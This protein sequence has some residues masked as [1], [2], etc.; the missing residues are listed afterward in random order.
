VIDQYDRSQIGT[1]TFQPKDEKNQD[2][3]EPT[4]DINYRK[5]AECGPPAFNY[6]GE[7]NITNRGLAEFID[8]SQEHKNKPQKFTQS[9]IDEVMLGPAVRSFRRDKRR[10]RKA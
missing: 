7:L 2:S 3:I 9:D 6:D 1:G 10:G 5:I 8:A 4:G